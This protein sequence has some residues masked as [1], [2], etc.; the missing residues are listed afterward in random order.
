MGFIKNIPELILIGSA[1]LVLIAMYVGGQ[2]YLEARQLR[3]RF[4]TLRD[5]WTAIEPPVREERGFGLDGGKF[6]EIQAKGK[7]LEGTVRS[8]WLA[9][10]EA[11]DRYTVS[12]R[13]ACMTSPGEN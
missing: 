5:A 8:W 9:V 7:Q 2:M 4:T 11:F 12:F 6:A 3:K 10:D 13:Q 1:V